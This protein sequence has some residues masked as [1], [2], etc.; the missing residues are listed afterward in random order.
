M[1]KIIRLTE[2]ELTKVIRKIIYESSIEE[3]KPEIDKTLSNNQSKVSDLWDITFLGNNTISVSP[4]GQNKPVKLNLSFPGKPSFKVEGIRK[5]LGGG[6]QWQIALKNKDFP[7]TWGIFKT[8]PGVGGEYGI[9]GYVYDRRNKKWI[10]QK[11]V[12]TSFLG[13]IEYEDYGYT[14]S[15]DV[16]LRFSGPSQDKMLK[17]ILQK[18]KASNMRPFQ[19]GIAAIDA[20]ITLTPMA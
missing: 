4:T 1:K 3:I 2:S 15:D 18:L 10:S 14:N 16:D 8:L 7:L 5:S 13:K 17:P 9:K 19:H 12:N 11:D 20:Q 6:Y